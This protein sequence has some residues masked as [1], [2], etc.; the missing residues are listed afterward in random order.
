MHRESG[1]VYTLL[2]R[3]EKEKATLGVCWL[4]LVVFSTTHCAVLVGGQDTQAR[5]VIAAAEQS[6]RYSLQNALSIDS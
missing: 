5:V 1:Q 3:K 2:E 4:G 6:K